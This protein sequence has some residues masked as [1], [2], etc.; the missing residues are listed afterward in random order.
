M[1]RDKYFIRLVTV[2]LERFN[3][4]AIKLMFGF[5]L[6]LINASSFKSPFI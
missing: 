6:A 4:S 5:P 2:T 1:Q 3:C